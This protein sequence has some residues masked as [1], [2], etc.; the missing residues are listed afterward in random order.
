MSPGEAGGF[1]CLKNIQYNI[2]CEVSIKIE[3]MIC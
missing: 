1:F 2:D 3:E